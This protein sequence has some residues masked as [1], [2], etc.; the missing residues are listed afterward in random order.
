MH[1]DLTILFHSASI[2]YS[3]HPPVVP[4]T[5]HPFRH[6][7]VFSLGPAVVAPHHTTPVQWTPHPT[8]L[9]F[10]FRHHTVFS[11]RPACSF[12]NRIFNQLI[13]HQCK[14]NLSASLA[15]C[16]ITLASGLILQGVSKKRYFLDLILVSVP[17]VRFYFFTCVLESEF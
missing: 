16:N 12:Q 11:L 3:A 5:P 4:N 6:H 7:T 8:S 13:T 2:F 1:N 17:E 10:A 14:T 15:C 9:L